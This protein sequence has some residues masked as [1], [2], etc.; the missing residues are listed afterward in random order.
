MLRMSSRSIAELPQQRSFDDLGTPLHE[1]VFCVID[2][3][4]TGGN[5][6]DDQ[7]TEVGAV[8]VQGGRCLG[9]F[10]T[11][12]NPGRAIPPQ[13]TVLTG[14]SDVLV[15][16]APRIGAVLPSLIEFVGDAVIVGHNVGFDVGFLRAACERH[17]RPPLAG[18]VIDTVALA[19]RLVRDEVPDCKLGTLASRFR[20]DHRPSHRGTRRR[21]GDRRPPPPAHRAGVGPRRARAR[22]SAGAR[23]ARGAPAS[24]QA[25]D[26][27]RPAPYARGVH[28]PRAARRRAVRRQGHESAPTG[29]LVLRQ[30]GSPQGRPDVARDPVGHPSRPARRAHCGGDREPADRPTPP[31]LQP[32]RHTR[33]PLLLRPPRRRHAVATPLGREEPVRHR[34]APRT[35]AV[36]DDGEPGDRGDPERR[37]AAALFGPSRAELHAGPRRHRVQRCATRRGSLPVRRHRRRSGVRPSGRTR[38]GRTQRTSPSC[39]SSCSTTR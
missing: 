19:R 11:L 15:S 32:C 20:L 36:A 34:P 5:R 7:I 4:T 30:R 35:A 27:R 1:V 17:G 38:G 2:L 8:K 3:E 22:R 6:N 9:T 16:A 14:L 18:T 28:V 21:A 37:P 31:P 12:V 25:E 33:R 10:Q 26:D 29:P 24:R 13:I 23:Q 39:W